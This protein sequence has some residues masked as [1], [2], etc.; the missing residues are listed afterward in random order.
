[1]CLQHHHTTIFIW[2]IT[3]F[4]FARCLFTVSFPHF[5]ARVGRVAHPCPAWNVPKVGSLQKFLAPLSPHRTG[6]GPDHTQRQWFLHAALPLAS[7]PSWLTAFLRLEWAPSSFYDRIL[8]ARLMGWQE[9]W[10]WHTGPQ[11]MRTLICPREQGSAW[12]PLPAFMSSSC[13][14][15]QGQQRPL[16]TA[17]VL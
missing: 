6:Y 2:L 13:P 7:P 17:W 14:R 11:N 9:D 10:R 3:G 12:A 4:N 1:M 5:I 8:Q 16:L 15:T